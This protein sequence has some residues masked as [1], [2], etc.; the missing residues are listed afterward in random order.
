MDI[1]STYWIASCTKLLTSVCALQQVEQ[2]KVDLDEDIT[3]ILPEMKEFPVIEADETAPGG[4]TLKPRQK[5]IT[6]RH[7]LTHTSGVGYDFISPLIQAW[8]QKNGPSQAELAGKVLLSYSTPLLFE[9]GEGWVYGAG[10]DWAGIMVERLNPGSTLGSYMLQKIFTPLGMNSTTFHIDKSP[11]ILARLM[12]AARREADGTLTPSDTNGWPMAMEEHSGGAGLWSSATDYMKV[13]ADLV[14]P[15]PTLLEPSTINTILASPQIP[16]G[17]PGLENLLDA[18]GGAV[19][20]NAAALS[21]SPPINYGCGGMVTTKDTEI[22][23]AGS[24]SWGGLPNL[25]WFLNRDLGVAAMYATQIL[26]YGDALSIELSN[27]FFVEVLRLH[28]ENQ[29]K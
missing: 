5:Q 21:G 3:R 2:G 20:A 15:E 27:K 11:E 19:A 18:R 6:L 22:L 25:K 13:L 10:I 14:S 29:A 23:P 12:P 16:P 9:P 24:L 8:R 7:L 1:E 28:R 26:P 4:F 17:N